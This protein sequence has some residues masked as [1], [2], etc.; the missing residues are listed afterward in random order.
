MNSRELF[1]SSSV[2]FDGFRVMS[3]AEPAIYQRNNRTGYAIAL[4]GSTDEHEA[5]NLSR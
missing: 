5:E 1:A 2:T 4:F 3:M